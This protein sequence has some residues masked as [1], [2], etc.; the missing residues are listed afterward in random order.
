VENFEQRYARFPGLNL[1]FEVR[2]GIIKHSHDFE[3]G[4]QPEADDYLPGLR[5]PLEAQLIDLA[6]EVAYNTADLDDGFAAGMIE[7][8]DVAECVP[9]YS[10][11]YE[12]VETQ[13]PGA[14]SRQRFQE[15][16]RQLI[17]ALVSGLIEG[18]VNRARQAAISSTED[19]RAYPRRIAAFTPE[20]ADTS[21]QL[22]RF[23]HARVYSSEALCGHRQQSTTMIAELFQFFL[24][25][26]G[27]LPQAYLE[28]TM[29]EPAHRLV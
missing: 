25:H 27:R 17:D 20:A 3:P 11:I 29:A 21:A 22:K 16:L 1:T 7:A 28:Q 9:A 6:D 4:E 13:Y 23:L 2:E 14:T 18:T 24:D 26:P 12:S 15:G 10:S 8:P 19:V 5:P